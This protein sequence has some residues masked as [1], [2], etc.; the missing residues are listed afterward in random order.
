M[1]DSER[2]PLHFSSQS[3]I[4]EIEDLLHISVEPVRQAADAGKPPSPP[5]ATIPVF[6]SP[7]P[8]PPPLRSVEASTSGASSS[9]GGLI[10]FGPAHTTLTEPVWATLKRDLLQ[11]VSN[12]R[13]VVFPNPY[14][15]DAGRALRDWDLWGPFFFIIFLAFILSYNASAD[16]EC[17]IQKQKPCTS[18]FADILTYILRKWKVCS[19]RSLYSCWYHVLLR[20]VVLAI[21]FTR[22]NFPGKRPCCCSKNIHV[23]CEHFQP[24]VFAVVFAVLSAGAIVLTLNVVLLGGSIIFLQSLSVLGYCLFPLAIG[25]SVCMAKDDK[26]FRSIVVLATVTW[27]SWAVYPFVSTAVPP[28]RKALAVYPVL[29]L[30]VSM[31]F[32][33]LANN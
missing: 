32:L 5:R 9:A 14:R 18:L 3:D 12:L 31:G 30:Y 10:G 6:S 4:D 13:I 26:I 8:P 15:K 2:I 19:I 22:E 7:P 17:R 23:S 16:R 29:L 20:I 33:V 25:A 27:S 28:S 11:V 21:I 1:T 24:K